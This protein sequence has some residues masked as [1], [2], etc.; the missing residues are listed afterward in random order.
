MVRGRAYGHSALCPYKMHIPP[1]L[2][3]EFGLIRH[4]TDWPFK[5]T[6]GILRPP[7]NGVL[8]RNSMKYSFRLSN[9]RRADQKA[10][11]LLFAP[12]ERPRNGP[13]LIPTGDPYGSRGQRPRKLRPTEVRPWKGRIRM[14][15]HWACVLRP[16]VMRPFQGR[17]TSLALSGGVAPGY[18]LVPLQGTK[19]LPV[20][21]TPPAGAERS[22]AFSEHPSWSLRGGIFIPDN[23]NS[24]LTRSS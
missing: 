16:R 1:T 7:K 22:S 10:F 23:C 18:Y 11:F 9:L 24:L 13:S 5:E 12:P 19:R 4:P 17:G 8:S 14:A 20:G 15:S 2:T 3:S 21:L 6:A